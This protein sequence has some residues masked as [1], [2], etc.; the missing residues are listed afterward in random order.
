MWSSPSPL[1]YFCP[2]LGIFF[3]SKMLSRSISK[4]MIF[5]ALQVS[6]RDGG[7]SKTLHFLFLQAYWPQTF[8]SSRLDFD[9]FCLFGFLSKNQ[10]KHLP[11]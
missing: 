4:S 10:N 9:Y 3:L 5:G 8:N 7:Y 1:K 2:L 11:P 6:K